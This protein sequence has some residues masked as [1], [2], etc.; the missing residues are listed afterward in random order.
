[1]LEGEPTTTISIRRGLINND[2]FIRGAGGLDLGSTS[3]DPTPLADVGAIAA[4][5]A[6]SAAA[7]C[8]M[9]AIFSLLQARSPARPR[10]AA[11][12]PGP[13]MLLVAALAI[14]AVAISGWVAHDVLEAL[15][16]T[17]DEV[18][19][20]LQADWLLDGQLW[21]KVV[22]YQDLIS[23]PFTY[24]DGSRWLAHYPPGWPA[25][26]AVGVAA[27]IPWTVSP[28][29]G[30]IY[31]VLLYFAGRELQGPTLGLTAAT[32]GLIS[33]MARLIFGSMHSHALAATLILAALVMAHCARRSPGWLNAAT[34]GLALG[35]AFGLRP[36]TAAA[37]A[38]P[39]LALALTGTRPSGN[40]LRLSTTIAPF[41]GGFAL[42][43][44]PTLVASQLIPGSAFSYPYSL[45]PARCSGPQASRSDC[46]K[47]RRPARRPAHRAAPAPKLVGDWSG[48]GGHLDDRLAFAPALCVGVIT[49]EVRG[50]P[51]GCWRR[52]CFA[53][54]W[55]TSGRGV[56]G[57]RSSGPECPLRGLRLRCTLLTRSRFLRS[58]G[59]ALVTGRVAKDDPGD[60]CIPG[61]PCALL[62]QPVRFCRPGLRCIAATTGSTDLSES[63]SKTSHRNGRSSFLH[64]ASGRAGPRPR[65]CWISVPAPRPW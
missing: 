12:H 29:L 60:R 62:C 61:S 45:A 39:M 41:T 55:P 57:C 16:H 65:G 21:S 13:T 52:W 49:P 18:V 37:V 38:L 51:T 15:P 22:P 5:L 44:F 23:V 17:P 32:L 4:L 26:L 11:S 8:L 50:L 9:I 14:A 27:G 47:P 36:L 30:G 10:P 19:Y 42:A 2:F 48:S 53:L 56:M 35:A 3:I 46:V 25:L 43:G 6:R 1:M 24:I 20:L 54:R 33:P 64:P 34:A 63:S 31:V 40:H 7:A 28:L 58:C 59:S